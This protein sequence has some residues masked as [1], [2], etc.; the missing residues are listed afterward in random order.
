M[1]TQYRLAFLDRNACD[2]FNKALKRALKGELYASLAKRCHL[3]SIN[4]HPDFKPKSPNR[5]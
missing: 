4:G 2:L 1:L 3:P 5:G